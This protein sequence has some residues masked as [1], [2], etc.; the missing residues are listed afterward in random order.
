MAASRTGVVRC[1]RDMRALFQVRVLNPAPLGYDQKFS[2]QNW[3][4]R[5]QRLYPAVSTQH[6]G[7]KNNPA[8]FRVHFLMFYFVIL[9]MLIYLFILA[10][11]LY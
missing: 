8:F 1:W 9:A 7:W 2:T 11:S 5:T 10:F 3:V 4:K 6:L